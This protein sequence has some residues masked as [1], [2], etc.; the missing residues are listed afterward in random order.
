MKTHTHKLEDLHTHTLNTHNKRFTHT[1][2]LEDVHI[3]HTHIKTHPH[4]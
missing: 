3:H 1:Y 4:T 2:T